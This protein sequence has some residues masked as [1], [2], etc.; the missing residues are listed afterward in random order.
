M[1][2]VGELLDHMAQAYRLQA[3]IDQLEIRE[4]ASPGRFKDEIAR[5]QEELRIIRSIPL[6][7]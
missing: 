7:M 3:Q 1:M 2:T 5:L 4:M 6:N